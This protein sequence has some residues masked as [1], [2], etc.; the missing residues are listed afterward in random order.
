MLSY[1]RL[2]RQAFVIFILLHADW[3]GYCLRR[4]IADS[5]TVM[6]LLRPS[7]AIWARTNSIGSPRLLA[8][9]LSVVVVV[10]R[11]IVY[12]VR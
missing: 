4:R 8:A 12:L 2:H 10:F 6:L 5:G 1:L 7:E 9:S 3:L 11:R